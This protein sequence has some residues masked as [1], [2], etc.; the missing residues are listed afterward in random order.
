MVSRKAPACPI[1][2]STEY[3]LRQGEYFCRMCNTQ[4][5]ELGMETI[6]DDETVPG[7]LQ[8]CD[9]ISVG[10]KGKKK[11]DK[12]RKRR[13]ALLEAETWSTAELFSFVLRGWI[14]EIRKLGIDVEIAVLQ[15]WSLYLRYININ[16]SYFS[17]VNA[18]PPPS[19]FVCQ[20]V[21]PKNKPA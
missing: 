12:E 5:Q 14:L 2:D 18:T 15:L 10:S 19:T 6:M 21:C 17:V 4:S 9:Q 1:C 8:M 7:G 13:R 20:S 3:V 11:S 16:Q